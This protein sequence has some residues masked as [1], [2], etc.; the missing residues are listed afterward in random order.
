MEIEGFE[1]DPERVLAAAAT[2]AASP[3]VRIVEADVTTY[4]HGDQYDAA[5][6][7]DVLHHIAPTS[8][9]GLL[10]AVRRAVRPG[11]TVLVKDIATTPRWKHRFNAF[12]D[13]AVAGD[14]THCSSPEQM[15]SMLVDAGLTSDGRPVSPH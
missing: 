9:P 2:Q 13:R 6:L 8:Q 11:G 4:E 7:V 15:A 10:E 3:R 1:I 12:H 14:D 5:I